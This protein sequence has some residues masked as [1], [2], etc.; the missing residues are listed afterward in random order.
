MK[1]NDISQ[2]WE[3]TDPINSDSEKKRLECIYG[4]EIIILKDNILFQTIDFN[5]IYV[6]FLMLTVK[7]FIAD[8][9]D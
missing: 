1:T 3:W 8:D 4:N 5:P 7:F 2:G 6:I 9:Y